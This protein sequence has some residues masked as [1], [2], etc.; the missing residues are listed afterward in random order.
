MTH[1]FQGP[2]ISVIFSNFDSKES[3]DISFMFAGC[4]NLDII[5]SK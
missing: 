1:M 4:H 2:K 5:L 3:T